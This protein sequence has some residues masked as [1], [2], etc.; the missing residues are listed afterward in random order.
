MGLLTKNRVVPVTVITGFLGSGKS[1]LLNHILT[2]TSHGQK[3]AVIENELGDV[4][5]DNQIIKKN[6][7]EVRAAM[8]YIHVHLQHIIAY[9][10]MH[11]IQHRKSSKLPMDA[12]AAA[13]A[14]TWCALFPIFTRR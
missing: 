10:T 3:F 14:A 8:P 6:V 7:D 9:L 1:T 5:I 13:S 12:S 11:I 4:A 2:D